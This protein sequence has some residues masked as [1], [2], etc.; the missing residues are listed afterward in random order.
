[1]SV[2]EYRKRLFSIDQHLGWLRDGNRF[3][4]LTQPSVRKELDLAP[5]QVRQIVDLTERRRAVFRDHHC[6]SPETCR[7]NLNELANQER[8]L[9]RELTPEQVRRLKQIACQQAGP[10]AFGDPEITAALR[11]T[12]WQKEQIRTIQAET[13][14][15]KRPGHRPCGPR[16]EGGKKNEVAES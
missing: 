1:P 15:L 2:P 9:V 14:R 3:L 13:W 11:L 5:Y 10:G 4:L 8:A 16:P 7:A 12:P 6:F